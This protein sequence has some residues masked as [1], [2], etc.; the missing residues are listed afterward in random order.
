MESCI[1]LEELHA[2][3]IDVPVYALRLPRSLQRLYVFKTFDAEESL[4]SDDN[5]LVKILTPLL[6]HR[7]LRSVSISELESNDDE[8]NLFKTEELCI[9][10]GIEYTVAENVSA[11][12]CFSCYE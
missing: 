7:N 1:C 11:A 5:R 6:S 8:R 12:N 2:N 4:A 3:V 10:A 9:G